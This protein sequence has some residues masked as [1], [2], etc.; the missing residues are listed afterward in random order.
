MQLW[1]AAKCWDRML[2]G[3]KYLL[4]LLLVEIIVMETQWLSWLLAP[5]ATHL[6]DEER[7]LV[8]SDGKEMDYSR[9]ILP[10]PVQ[11]LEPSWVTKPAAVTHSWQNEDQ[12][13]GLLTPSPKTFT[14]LDGGWILVSA[15]KSGGKGL[16]E[17]KSFFTFYHKPVCV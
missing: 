8:V 7:P 2:L 4:R 15:S 14:S 11:Q 16:E 12:N 3:G 17:A 13:S 9:E 10:F 6:W 1:K 5:H